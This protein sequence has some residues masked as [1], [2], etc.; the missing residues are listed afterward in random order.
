MSHAAQMSRPESDQ[1]LSG[2]YTLLSPGTEAPPKAPGEEET[3]AWYFDMVGGKVQR[4]GF[5]EVKVEFW[6]RDKHD[7]SGG[8]KPC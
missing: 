8:R 4:E 1:P 2:C 3:G 7:K 5:L 6:W